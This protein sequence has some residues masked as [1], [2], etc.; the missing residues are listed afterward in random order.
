MDK[1]ILDSYADLIVKAGANVQKGQ[2]V[3]IRTNPCC[4]EFAA[5]VAKKCYEAGAKQ[6]FV[7]W[8]S[9]SLNKVDYQYAAEEQLSTVLPFEEACHKFM[10]DNNPVLIW[11]DSDDPDGLK[12]VD[13]QKVATV[14]SNK[15]KV[16]AKYREAQQ[17]KAQWTIAGVPSKEW[18]MKVFPKL[19][20][21]DA[22][23][24][25]W[26]AILTTAR[27]LDGNGIANWDKH[28]VDLKKRCAYLNSLK[29]AKLH[30]QS[31]TGTDF[32][33]GLI[34]GV[35][36]LGGGEKDLP[37]HF[38]QPNIPSEECFTSPMKGKAEGL[39]VAS[40]PL[41]YQGQMIEDF[42]VRFH[43]GKA[44]EVTAKKGLE[45]LKSILTLDK[46]SAYLGECALVPFNSPINQTGLLFFNTL[47]DE[48][49]ACHLALG[50]GFT[51]L[52]PNYEKYTDEEVRSFGINK[53]IS[54]VDFMIGDQYLNITGTTVDGNEVAIFRNGAWA[55]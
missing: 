32:T 41:V 19:T 25:L 53:S 42:T 1:K 17:N 33:V 47:Y 18:A 14:K 46:G 35:I 6:V 48:N 36:F 28:E 10:A 52:Y 39:V 12:G 51:E 38:F 2:Y 21:A 4:E 3:V 5:L 7:H 23:E 22:I 31:K 45:V 24:A 13:A 50:E 16:L 44:V 9:S 8:I 15:F 29:L 54:H 55:F 11:L 37:G 27:C 20:E 30:Y 43:E 26:K 49:A 40:K 34:P